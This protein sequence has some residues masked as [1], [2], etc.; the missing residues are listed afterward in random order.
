MLP[1]IYDYAGACNAINPG[2]LGSHFFSTY[3]CASFVDS[4]I[5]LQNVVRSYSIFNRSLC[6]A[7]SRAGLRIIQTGL[8]GLT[9]LKLIDIV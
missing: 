7:S 2:G 4:F 6:S 8:T 3:L 5:T 1:S 9:G